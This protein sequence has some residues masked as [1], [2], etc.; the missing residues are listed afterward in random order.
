[1]YAALADL[2]PVKVRVVADP[3][4]A[5]LAGGLERLEGRS[6][7]QHQRLLITER[8][9]AIRTDAALGRLRAKIAGLEGRLEG[10]SRAAWANE[11]VGSA[12]WVAGWF[13]AGLATAALVMG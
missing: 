11:P 1:V 9:L 12:W 7:I 3:L 8:R 5:R 13:V 4:I 6:A 2:V 10:V